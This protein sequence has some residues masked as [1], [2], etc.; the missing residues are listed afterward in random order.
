[1]EGL[2]TTAKTWID[3]II[4]WASAQ[5]VD[6]A[7]GLA[8]LLAGWWAARRVSDAVAKFFHRTNHVDP[9]VES[10]LASFLYYALLAVF[11]VIAL[12]LMGVHTTSLIAVLGAASLAIGLALQGSLTSL[13][14]GVMIILIR[15][16]KLGDY[17]EA[18]GESGT[19]KSIT[20]FHTELATYDNIRKILPNSAVWSSNIT[21]YTTYDTRMLDL[22]VGIAYEDDIDKGLNILRT[23]AQNHDKVAKDT[24]NVFVSEIG[25]SAIDL[26]LRCHIPTPDFWPTKRDLVKSIKLTIER[27]G[28]SF[29]F[30]RR[31][32]LVRAPA[33]NASVAAAA[34]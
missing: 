27:E 31:E 24:I 29:P 8:V 28:L 18:A 10:F 32:V 20:L 5:G 9:I 2:Q 23:I 6:I 11:M 4:A 34:D 17:I 33:S 3:P 19:V 30:P 13:A 16:F 1:M 7:F 12:N 26:T 21:N 25:E 14:A 22:T 15:P